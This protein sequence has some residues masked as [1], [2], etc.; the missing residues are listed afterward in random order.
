MKVGAVLGSTSCYYNVEG[1]CSVEES[2]LWSI[3]QSAFCIDPWPV[4]PLEMHPVVGLGSSL[5]QGPWW[6][7]RYCGVL[8]TWVT[9]L[10]LDWWA[11]YVMLASPACC[12]LFTS[13]LLHCLNQWL[14]QNNWISPGFVCDLARVY[15]M[16]W[17][18]GSWKANLKKIVLQTECQ[19]LVTFISC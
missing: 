19:S 16:L 1:L 7:Y 2:R 5:V 18:W 10:N 17:N 4:I 14:S 9:P 8:W 12:L 11:L 15:K 6:W 3:T 13:C